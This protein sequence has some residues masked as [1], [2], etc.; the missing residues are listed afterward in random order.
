MSRIGGVL[1]GRETQHFVQRTI[2]LRSLQKTLEQDLE[3]RIARFQKD[4]AGK[5]LGGYPMP[6]NLEIEEGTAGGRSWG[7]DGDRPVMVEWKDYRVLQG[8]DAIRLMGRNDILAE[9]LHATPKPDELMTLHCKGYFDDIANKRYGFVFESPAS[10]S[11][12]VLSLNKLLNKP[13]P[14]RLPTLHQRYQ[15][16]YQLAMTLSILLTIGW[17][18]KGIRSHNVLFAHKEGDTRWSRPYLCGFAYARPDKP[19][20]FSEK[21]EHSERFNVYRHPLAQGQPQEGYHKAFDIYSLGVLL[22]EIATWRPAFSLWTHD[23]TQFR[24]ELC[25]ASNQKR[26]AHSMGIDYRDAMLKCLD[27]SFE[28]DAASTPKAFLLEI[29]EALRQQCPEAG[30][31]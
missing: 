13:P 17:L 25:K 24:R 5:S 28:G 21:L 20:E 16:A 29:V 14:E 30:A 11:E 6:A 3:K 31:W 8:Q 19:D 18:H 4:F 23:A 27:G 22:F 15:L 7:K 10:G 9:M 12:G 2:A 1:G 26:I